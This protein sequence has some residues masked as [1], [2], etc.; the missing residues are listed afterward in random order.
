VD[1]VVEDLSQSKKLIRFSIPHERVAEEIEAA[2]GEVRKSASIKGFRPGHVPERIVRARFADTIR[3]EAIG[4]LVPDALREALVENKLRPVGE[5]KVSDVHYEKEEP[6]TFTATVEVVPSFELPPYKGIRVVAYKIEPPTDKE[7]DDF[8]EDLRQARATLVPVEDRPVQLGDSIIAT[9]EQTVDGKTETLKD[10][11]IEVEQERL[12]PG[13]A[14]ELVGIERS[15]PKRFELAV[16][17]DYPNAKIAGKTIGY[18]VTVSEIKQKK[19]PELSDEFAREIAG[20]DSL[21]ALRAHVG[22]RLRRQRA[23]DE[24]RRQEGVV[25]DAIVDAADFEVPESL[26]GK[27]TKRNVERAYQRGYLAGVP[28]EKMVE[29]HDEIVKNASVAS[30]RQIKLALLLDRIGE[31][32]GIRVTDED[33]DAYFE[34]AGAARGTSGAHVR[35]AYAKQEGAVESLRD[36]LLEN[37]VRSFLMEHAEIE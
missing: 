17:A 34:Q 10:R 25:L 27:Q 35:E 36:E 1:A 14:R 28:R 16:P 18:A 24:R 6:L 4:R 31:A 15:A 11:A 33:L 8:I 21:A 23:S 2:L 13:L 9:L 26:R 19:L 20:A 37:K 5:P 30:T 7:I 29:Q 22:E 3:S 12:I 32:E